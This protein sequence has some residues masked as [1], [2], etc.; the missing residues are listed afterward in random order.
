MAPEVRLQNEGCTRASDM[1]SYGGLLFV[2]LYP[3]TPPV[4]SEDGGIEV[5]E[6][7]NV[8]VAALV[9]KLLRKEAKERPSASEAL[10]YPLFA[11]AVARGVLAEQLE[12]KL[13]EQAAE[14]TALR[15]AEREAQARRERE[16]KDRAERLRQCFAC[17]EQV[18][19]DAGV[20]CRAGHF[21]CSGCL[22]QEVKEQVSMEN[23]GAFKRAKLCVQCRPCSGDSWLDIAAL[24]RHLAE[25]GFHAYLRAREAV[26]VGDA[27]EEQEERHKHKVRELEEQMQKLAA[28]RDRAVL[29]AR[30]KIIEDILTL[31]CPRQHCRRA[32]LDFDGCFALTCGAC[33]CAFCAYCLEDCGRDA[34]S[35]VANCRYNIAPGKSVHATFQV[36]ERAQRERRTRLLKQ[37]LAQHVEAGVRGALIEALA[38][39]LADLGIDGGQLLP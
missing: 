12:R 23:I 36:F 9:R 34:H 29:Q 20:E 39:D 26:Q 4:T 25:D 7:A 8:H 19:V 21:M 31:K 18:D 35:H 38:R 30:K 17:F 3:N 14:L 11:A 27:L 32:F 37:H 13:R 6:H 1:Y 22:N 16:D 24:T 15:E 2:A 10:A 28:G 33:T 5:G